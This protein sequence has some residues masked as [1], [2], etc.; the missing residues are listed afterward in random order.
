MDYRIQ[1]LLRLLK[2]APPTHTLLSVSV[3]LCK[4]ANREEPVDLENCLNS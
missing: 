4:T 1:L 3:L 2:D